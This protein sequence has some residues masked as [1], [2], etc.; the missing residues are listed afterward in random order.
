MQAWLLLVWPELS[1]NPVV[2][3]R[4]GSHCLGDTCPSK[5]VSMSCEASIAALWVGESLA[6]QCLQAPSPVQV[7]PACLP[8]PGV[9]GTLTA[10]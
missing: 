10:L 2:T 7:P 6:W 1:S 8:G 3:L 4:W 5:R 9:T